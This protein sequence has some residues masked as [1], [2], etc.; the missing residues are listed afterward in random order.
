MTMSAGLVVMSD[1]NQ[2]V[3]ELL[4]QADR[5]LNTAKQQGKNRVCVYS[6][7]PLIEKVA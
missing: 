3:Q 4:A 7:G 6:G 2:N 1:N 5:A